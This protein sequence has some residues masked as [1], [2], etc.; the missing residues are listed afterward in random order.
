[1]PHVKDAVSVSIDESR[2]PA[3]ISIVGS[4]EHALP[5]TLKDVLII[6][7]WPKQNPLQSL[8][9][10]DSK[11]NPPTRSFAAQLPN[12]GAMVSVNAWPAG[13]PL[14]LAGLFAAARLNDRS[15]LESTLSL[16]YYEP[17]AKNA[18]LTMGLGSEAIGLVPSLEMLSIY[19]M[20]PPPPYLRNS[21]ANDTILR[22]NRTGG[23][24]LD[25]SGYFAQPCLI[26]MGSLDNAALPFPLLLDGDTVASEG[27]VMVRWVLP[28]PADADWIVPDRIPRGT[29]PL[30]EPPA[31]P[32]A[33]SQEEPEQR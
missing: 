17:I 3:Q 15:G 19:G 32:A 22:F 11:N 30:P 27:R 24:D 20:L 5:G 25:L 33:P 12:R 9:P 29:K 21:A 7:V 23:R 28:L 14:D 8:G 4:L 26:V 1:L 2:N 16:R 18:Q 10:V 6:H 13:Q 31:E